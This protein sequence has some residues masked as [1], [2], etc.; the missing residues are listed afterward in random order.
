[1]GFV[2]AL[3]GWFYTCPPL[4]LVYRGLGEVV[5]AGC[6][7]MLTVVSGYY[8]QANAFDLAMIPPALALAASILNVILINEYADRFSDARTGKRTGRSWPRTGPS[9]RPVCGLR[10]PLYPVWSPNA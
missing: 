9:N 3:C 10:N 4:K 5:I 6:S 1:L 8:L 7:G 2:G